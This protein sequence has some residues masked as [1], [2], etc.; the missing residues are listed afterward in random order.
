[1]AARARARRDGIDAPHAEGPAAS[2]TPQTKP[3]ATQ[4]APLANG[5]DKILAAT[6]NE[7]AMADQQR[8]QSDPIPVH[9]AL[10][11]KHG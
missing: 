2:Q 1:M 5:L 9:K 10:D 8:R 6:G 7:L 4:H 3:A 11:K